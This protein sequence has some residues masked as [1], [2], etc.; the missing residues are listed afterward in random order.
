M[1]FRAMLLAVALAACGQTGEKGAEA[2]PVDQ[3]DP[4]TLNIEIGRYGAMLS[5][6][7]D[8]TS[9][10]PGV[11]EPDP[12]AP[13]ELARSLR[14]TVWEYNVQRSELCAK[15]LFTDV[16]CGPAYEPVWIAEP[17]T[18]EPTMMLVACPDMDCS[19]IVFTGPMPIEQ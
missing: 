1:K 11:G 3:L 4:F 18:V 2:P 12:A 19:A 9:Q 16:A 6:V 14:E 17:D 13:R 5:Q 8:H 15:G 7:E 10:R